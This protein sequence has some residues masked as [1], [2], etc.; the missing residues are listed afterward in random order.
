[1]AP[2]YV[3]TACVCI[4]A[5]DVIHLQYTSHTNHL[6][7]RLFASHPSRQDDPQPTWRMI[8]TSTTTGY[9]I[10]HR[11]PTSLGTPTTPSAWSYESSFTI[12]FTTS[13]STLFIPLQSFRTKHLC[14]S[15]CVSP[16][17]IGSKYATVA[18][19][20]LPLPSAL[21]HS[22][23][24]TAPVVPGLLGLTMLPIIPAHLMP[25]DAP[26]CAPDAHLMPPRM[27]PDARSPHR[28]EKVRRYPR[29]LVDR[30]CRTHPLRVCL[31]HLP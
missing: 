25:P 26:G 24:M 18:G 5:S 4:T 3:R 2:G 29:T 11:Q 22:S 30:L 21:F 16:D 15:Q 19:L 14:L 23:Q 12:L 7:P 9:A 6:P 20:C 10:P 13:S 27:P 31:S 28:A 1:M 8:T 17:G